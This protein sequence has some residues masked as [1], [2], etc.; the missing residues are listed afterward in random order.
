MQESVFAWLKQKRL[1]AGFDLRRLAEKAKINPSQIS[2]IETGKSGLTLNS[3]ALLVWALNIDPDELTSKFSFPPL[4]SRN[5]SFEQLFST[6]QGCVQIDTAIHFS[7]AYQDKLPVAVRFI[8]KHIRPAVEKANNPVLSSNDL[9]RRVQAAIVKGELLPIPPTISLEQLYIYYSN[10]AVITMADAGLCLRLRRHKQSW[11]I[12]E[13]AA[14]SEVNKST[15][16]RLENDQSDRISLDTAV[17]LDKAL[18]AGGHIFSMFWAAAQL[19]AGVVFSDEEKKPE[20]HQWSEET[21]NLIDTLIKLARWSHTYDDPN[22]LW[23]K[24]IGVESREYSEETLEQ[25]NLL[26]KIRARFGGT[27]TLNGRDLSSLVD[28]VANSIPLNFRIAGEED[29][30]D[31]DDPD[32][33]KG[34]IIWNELKQHAGEDEFGQRALKLYG[35]NFLDNDYYGMFRVFVREL[36]MNDPVFFQKIA[37]RAD[38]E[39]RKTDAEM[40]AKKKQVL[41]SVKKLVNGEE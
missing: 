11:G 17:S 21:F 22:L 9:D 23:T 25:F 27:H 1:D 31:I 15:I 18:D 30:P 10:N 26:D 14:F 32:V 24:T 3:L 33:Q 12:E 38:E 39:Q 20:R 28:T 4:L 40:E 13:L 19:Q 29:A 8:E 16:H 5:P 36:L 6:Y 34:L 41:E 37:D 35:Q 2:R 7:T